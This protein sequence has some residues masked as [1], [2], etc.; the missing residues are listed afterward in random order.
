M[1]D[2]TER[3]D[4]ARR[5]AQSHFTHTERRD[6]LVRAEI[7]KE[8]AA[9]DAKTAKLR[10]LRLAKEATEKAEAERLAQENA[11]SASTQ[12]AKKPARRKTTRAA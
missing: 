2:P 10:A 6:E 1:S 3:R 9:I 12:S 5:T 8:R 7:A 4:A 11:K